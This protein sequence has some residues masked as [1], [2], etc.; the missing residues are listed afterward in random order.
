MFRNAR[1]FRIRC[2]S[3]ASEV[4]T[5]RPLHSSC[6]R[7]RG[8]RCI[9]HCLGSKSQIF[10]LSGYAVIRTHDTFTIDKAILPPSVR[11][12]RCPSRPN[13]TLRLRAKTEMMKS[14]FTCLPHES[15]RRHRRLPKQIEVKYGGYQLTK[16]E[17]NPS[18]GLACT[19]GYNC[20]Q[21][22]ARLHVARARYNRSDRNCYHRLSAVPVHRMTIRPSR[23]DQPFGLQR[24]KCLNRRTDLQT[25]TDRPT[26]FQRPTRGDREQKHSMLKH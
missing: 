3:A 5:N 9:S 7:T 11:V 20:L 17:P 8:R 19:I 1:D 14:L 4:T 16:F 22:S 12:D 18:I 24:R 25:N 21:G 15:R 26:F 23:S 6:L 2:R 13:Q 10:Y